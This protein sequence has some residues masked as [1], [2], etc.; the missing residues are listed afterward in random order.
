[1][2]PI[3]WPKPWIIGTTL[4]I[5][6][7]IPTLCLRRKRRCY[8]ATDKIVCDMRMG[9]HMMGAEFGASEVPPLEVRVSGTAELERVDV[10]KDNR[11]VFTHRP[12]RATRKA[13]F[14]FRDLDAASGVHY[15]YARVIQKDRNMAWVSPIWVKVE[16]Q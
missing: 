2:I 8:A 13:E 5:S 7:L 9:E 6:R 16:G 1:M 3:S 10:I 11:I 15:Y 12:D 4:P 14:T